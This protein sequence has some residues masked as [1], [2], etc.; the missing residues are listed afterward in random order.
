MFNTGGDRKRDSS[1]PVRHGGCIEV[2]GERIGLI[3]FEEYCLAGAKDGRVDCF[4]AA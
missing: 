1:N 3:G 4:G 2:G